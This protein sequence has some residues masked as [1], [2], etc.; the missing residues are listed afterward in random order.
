[1]NI[2]VEGMPARDALIRASLTASK[3]YLINYYPQPRSEVLGISL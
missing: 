1:M 2:T 3:D